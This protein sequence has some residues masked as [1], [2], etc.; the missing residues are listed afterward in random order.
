MARSPIFYFGTIIFF[1]GLI[2]FA[3]GVSEAIDGVYN[4]IMA[5]ES[6]SGFILMAVGFRATTRP[7]Q[8]ESS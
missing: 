2:L 3:A 4:V 6:V 8:R 1:I 5:V 7:G